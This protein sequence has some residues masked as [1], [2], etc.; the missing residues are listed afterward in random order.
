[1]LDL[2]PL[3]LPALCLFSWA[4]IILV[5]I[6]GLK[7]EPLL[8]HPLRSL[9]TGLMPCS[10]GQAA[11]IAACRCELLSSLLLGKMSFHVSCAHFWPLDVGSGLSCLFPSCLES[12]DLSLWPNVQTITKARSISANNIKEMKQWKEHLQ[13]NVDRHFLETWGKA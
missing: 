5:L 10:Q 12:S 9:N 4:L 3:A 7:L 11:P 2:A 8:P 6:L 1:M 13:E